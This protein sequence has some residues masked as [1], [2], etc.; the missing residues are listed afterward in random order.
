MMFAL[1]NMVP[2]KLILQPGGLLLSEL[3]IVDAVIMDG[4]PLSTLAADNGLFAVNGRGLRG[5]P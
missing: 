2:D 3:C 5:L 4:K 1:L